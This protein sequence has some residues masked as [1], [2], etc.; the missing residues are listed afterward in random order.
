M[1]ERHIHYCV[2]VIIESPKLFAG[3]CVPESDRF[4]FA[5]GGD[6]C[7]VGTVSHTV[8]FGGVTLQGEQVRVT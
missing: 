2:R 7:T 5:G 6:Q 8:D 1:A 3:C 4:V